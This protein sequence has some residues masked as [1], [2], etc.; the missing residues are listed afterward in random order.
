MSSIET[1]TTSHI[2]VPSRMAS[3]ERKPTAEAT[4]GPS[5]PPAVAHAIAPVDAAPSALASPSATAPAPTSVLMPPYRISEAAPFGAL[6]NIEVAAPVALAASNDPIEHEIAKILALLEDDSPAQLAGAPSAAATTAPTGG[7]LASLAAASAARDT[8]TGNDAALSRAAT[9]LQDDATADP[10]PTKATASTH[11][12]T[13]FEVGADSV[14]PPAPAV[15]IASTL[16]ATALDASPPDAT[17]APLLNAL[18][19]ADVASKAASASAH[20]PPP[21]TPPKPACTTELAARLADLFDRDGAGADVSASLAHPQIAAQSTPVEPQ[22]VDH[23]AFPASTPNPSVSVALEAPVASETTPVLAVSS[24][25]AREPM[26][27]LVDPPLPSWSS[28]AYASA[29]SPHNPAVESLVHAIR[30]AQS[31]VSP[32]PPLPAPAAPMAL[33]RTPPVDVRRDMRT[34]NSSVHRGYHEEPESDLARPNPLPGFISGMAL[35]GVV[36]AALWALL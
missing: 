1:I 18:V 36:G 24:S 17:G 15:A 8:T 33:Q 12:P 7:A 11:G 2:V 9:T 14:T 6:F 22:S 32:P 23:G 21:A 26:V 13:S 34:A 29:Q 28:G 16:A 25:D 19:A 20:L 3:R 10:V 35:S 4:H 5:K 31:I 27:T 30:A